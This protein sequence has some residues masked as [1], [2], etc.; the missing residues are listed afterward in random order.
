MAVVPLIGR[1]SL[2]PKIRGNIRIDDIKCSQDDKVSDRP[3]AGEDCLHALGGL[4]H[5]GRFASYAPA[6]LPW[7]SEPRVIAAFR[8]ACAPEIT[9]F[10][11]RK[12]RAREFAEELE[13]EGFGLGA[14]DIHPQ[15][16]A[17]SIAV[18]AHRDGDRLGVTAPGAAV[19]VVDIAPAGAP[20]RAR[21]GRQRVGG[22][23]VEIR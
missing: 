20:G 6:A 4:T 3:P 12:P 17:P 8:P 7:R 1:G 11:P 10:T 16:L 13:P 15:H 2:Q 5:V 9:S 22:G 18:D 14:A 19:E 21:G 23:E